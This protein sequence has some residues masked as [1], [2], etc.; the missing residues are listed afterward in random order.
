MS[1][2]SGVGP[3]PTS[4]KGATAPGFDYKAT[5][6]PPAPDDPVADV[7]IQVRRAS[8]ARPLWGPKPFRPTDA[9][10]PG[11]ARISEAEAPAVPAQTDLEWRIRT[12]S[13]GG[14]RS[15]WSAWQPFSLP[16]ERP[17]VAPMPVGTVAS[18][19]GKRLR[20]EVTIPRD[21]TQIASY[22]VQLAPRGPAGSPVWESPLWT[23]AGGPLTADRRPMG[24]S[25]AATGM[26]TGGF[27]FETLDGCPAEQGM[28]VGSDRPLVRIGSAKRI[29]SYTWSVHQY[30]RP[31]R[32]G[33][34]VGETDGLD[35]DGLC[36]VFRLPRLVR[37]DTQPRGFFFP[38]FD[39]ERG[40]YRGETYGPNVVPTSMDGHSGFAVDFNQGSD[41]DD[42]GHPVLA[43]APGR[44]K[45]VRDID[46]TVQI[47]HW[48]GAYMTE[49]THMK[50]IR[51]R[52]FSEDPVRGTVVAL[53][54][55]G[56]IGKVGAGA[57]HLH[58]RHYR[59]TPDGD[60]R[61]IKMAFGRDPCF[62]SISGPGGVSPKSVT[63]FRIR[64]WDPEPEVVLAVKVAWAD[65]TDSRMRRMR[66]S[67]AKSRAAFPPCP[68]PGCGA[69][70]EMTKIVHRYDGPTL[71][72]GE[73]SVRYRCQD[74]LGTESRWA[75]DH[76]VEVATP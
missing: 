56:G 75:Y 69:T 67:V 3:T 47:R 32:R 64:G 54:R 52:P 50:D 13:A 10:P 29:R 27:W 46:G 31:V 22:E 4:P 59:R 71:A 28:K 5:F 76:S 41:D 68:D 60:Y 58:H 65:G 61:P 36:L 1:P 30:G 37:R 73:Y 11:G 35:D 34:G 14:I 25:R 21:A 33:K 17:E 8:D 74:D 23:D 48:G 26:R 62:A 49:Y 7:R 18:L 42:A 39:R 2:I 51:V 70:H 15:P 40:T 12:R 57:V 9:W 16:V 55:I 72:P 45:M 44:V 43:A 38:P 66:F 24:M 19:D 20:A 6:E 53:Q 63:G